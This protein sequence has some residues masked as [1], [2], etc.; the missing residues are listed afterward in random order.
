MRLSLPAPPKRRWPGNDCRPSECS[1]GSDRSRRS[2]WR[3]GDASMF[4]VLK[5]AATVLAKACPRIATVAVLLLGRGGGVGA[6]SVVPDTAPGWCV[7]ADAE[8]LRKHMDLAAS[9]VKAAQ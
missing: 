9:K 8:D 3:F 4:H 2:H 7:V 1:A 5:P 6:G